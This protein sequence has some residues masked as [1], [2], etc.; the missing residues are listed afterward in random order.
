MH[1]II[2]FDIRTKFW[3]GE[4][5]PSCCR[6]VPQQYLRVITVLSF[7]LCKTSS[8][9]RVN[10]LEES[11]IELSFF[12]F[13]GLYIQESLFFF[14]RVF[15]ELF[16]IFLWS[17]VL[18]DMIRLAFGG[19]DSGERCLRTQGELRTDR[20]F[21]QDAGEHWTGQFWDRWKYVWICPG[22]IQVRPVTTASLLTVASFHSQK[23][24]GWVIDYM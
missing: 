11:S 6:M 3:K 21:M 24:C 9:A 18:R 2:S 5:G 19:G 14:L 13:M 15:P 20:G 10:D 12:R 16:F 7:I 8:V 17:C 4:E 23:H 22:W 1:S